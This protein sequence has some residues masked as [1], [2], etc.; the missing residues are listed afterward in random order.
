MTQP[1]ETHAD[2]ADSR[3]GSTNTTSDVQRRGL[4]FERLKTA[5]IESDLVAP[6]AFT[7]FVP[8][9]PKP[10]GSSS[11]FCPKGCKGNRRPIVTSAQPSLK[12]WRKTADNALAYLFGRREMFDG[13]LVTIMEFVIPRLASHG[14]KTKPTAEK[15]YDADKLERAVNDALKDAGVIRDDGRICLTLR[16]K[17]YAEIGERPGVH[18]TVGHLNHSGPAA[19]PGREA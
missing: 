19:K 11:A 9:D 15:T 3:P 1:T 5:L 10:Q 6:G 14:T 17:R 13:P 4:D 7:A 2:R 12:A 16:S 18:V 8:G